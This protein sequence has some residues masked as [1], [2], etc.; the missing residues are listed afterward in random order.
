MTDYD[1]AH[2]DEVCYN[3][4]PSDRESNR[5]SVR[6]DRAIDFGCLWTGNWDLKPHH[7]FYCS[8]AIGI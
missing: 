6:F 2:S 8:N 3:G 4:N 1:V 5:F 7:C